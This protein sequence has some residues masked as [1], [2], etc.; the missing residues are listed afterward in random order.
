MIQNMKRLSRTGPGQKISDGHQVW[1]GGTGTCEGSVASS[2]AVGLGTAVEAVVDGRAVDIET[3]CAS[4]RQLGVTR[5]R[6]AIA[7]APSLN[8]AV[9]G[10]AGGVK[11]DTCTEEQSGNHHPR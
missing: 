9:G 6:A 5:V 8:M 7:P 10:Q 11:R 1:L 3:D 4:T 2:D